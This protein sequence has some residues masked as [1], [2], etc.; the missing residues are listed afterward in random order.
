MSFHSCCAVPG[1]V[2]FKISD[3][4]IMGDNFVLFLT[5]GR[6]FLA[7]VANM[8]GYAVG[9]QGVSYVLSDNVFRSTCGAQKQPW[10]RCV[11]PGDGDSLFMP[12]AMISIYS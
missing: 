4:I 6:V 10:S 1:N 8:L 12:P 11:H 3:I 5:S 7:Y 2:D 9:S